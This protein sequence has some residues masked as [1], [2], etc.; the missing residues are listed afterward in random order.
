MKWSS[1]AFVSV[2]LALGLTSCESMP[3]S[4][5]YLVVHTETFTYDRVENFYDLYE[6]YDVLDQSG[7]LVCHVENHSLSMEEG[8]PTRVSLP[9]GSYVIRASTKHGEVKIPA[10]IER[11]K[12]TS[13]TAR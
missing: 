6:P 10:V 8:G 5:G 1:L 7:A 13:V 2:S 3:R 9:P 12:L 11:G 4:K